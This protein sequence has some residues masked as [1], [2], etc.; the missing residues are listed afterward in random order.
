V[1]PGP[2][3]GY[4]AKGYLGQYLVVIPRHRLVAVRQMRSPEASAS[5]A[6]P[7]S[8]HEFPDMV[9]ALVGK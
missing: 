2:T 4:A 5:A 3:W 8:F 7:D 1:L 6:Q 9:R